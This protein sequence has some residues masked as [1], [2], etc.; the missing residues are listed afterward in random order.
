MLMVTVT[1]T[2]DLKINSDH[3]HPG[4]HVCAKF[5]KIRSVLCLVIIR[6]RFGLYQS[7]KNPLVRS[8]LLVQNG[9]GRVIFLT[10]SFGRTSDNQKSDFTKYSIFS[11]NGESG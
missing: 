2:F 10:R 4:T 6:T 1:L 7:P 9:Q 8:Y 3:L 5:D 11:P